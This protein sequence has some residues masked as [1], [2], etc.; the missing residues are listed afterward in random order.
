MQ[1]KGHDKQAAIMKSTRILQKKEQ[2]KA[3]ISKFKLEKMWV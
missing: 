2:K 3:G 1:K